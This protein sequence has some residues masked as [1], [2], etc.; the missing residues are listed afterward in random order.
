MSADRY[1]FNKPWEYVQNKHIGTGHSDQTK[2][3]WATN[4]QRDTLASHLGK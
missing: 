4:M 2:Y 3:E 1:S